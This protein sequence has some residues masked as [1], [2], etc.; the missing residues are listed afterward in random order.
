MLRVFSLRNDLRVQ[1]LQ[2]ELFFQELQ[3]V[4]QNPRSPVAAL[5]I[6]DQPFPTVVLRQ[7]PLEEPVVVQM[8]TA[9]S[10]QVQSVSPMRAVI[11]TST[12]ENFRVAMD[13]HANPIEPEMQAID[14]EKRTARWHL[15]PINGSRKNFVYGRF[16]MQ[17]LVT[18]G[19]T[20]S[21]TVILESP[22]SAPFVVITNEVQWD[23][24]EAALILH[25][26]FQDQLDVPW[27]L[28]ANVLQRHFVRGTRQNV[29]NPPRPLS[30]NELIFI[31]RHFFG[32]GLMASRQQFTDFWAW[33]GKGVQRL[34]TT[35]PLGAMWGAGLLWCFIATQDAVNLLEAE[36][37]GTFIVR[38]PE[39]HP[40]QFSI[41]YR[42]REPLEPGHNVGEVLVPPEAL[43]PQH[44]LPE[45]LVAQPQLELI[46]QVTAMTQASSMSAC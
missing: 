36:A 41:M 42:A 7:K 2:L 4:N 14:L 29:M 26:A 32:G 8:L 10:V 23:E 12:A 1:K 31:H 46:L 28:L 6:L 39:E 13:S 34:R 38:L 35:R 9:A 40:G 16:A 44:S 17:V 25:Y 5:A 24:T 21:H 37:P 30:T 3:L 22:P 15:K 33:F 45:L 27:L 19:G 18:T 20:V 11:T 43:G